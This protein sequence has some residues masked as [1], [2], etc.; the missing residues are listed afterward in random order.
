MPAAK[1]PK[2][3]AMRARLIEAASRELVDGDGSL[4]LSAVAARAGVSN[5]LPYR[6]F[7]SK[8]QLMAAVVDDFFDR[9]D[10]EIFEPTLEEV[11]SW[12]ER[13]QARMART[14]E[15]FYRDP[16]APVVVGLLS[17]DR[18]AVVALQARVERQV[19]AAARNIIRGQK[20]GSIGANLDPRLRAAMV[21]GGIHRT[22]LTA[23][24]SSPKPAP[25]HVTRELSH[26]VDV[27]LGLGEAGISRL[28]EHPGSEV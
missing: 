19:S 15:F 26:F 22:L 4:E 28:R 23:L 2:G 27:V 11:G 3:A 5:G 14:V 10:R 1:T 16:L 6:Y 17:G 8:A 13:E 20:E 7:A 9:F 18:D 12:R 25:E 24:A 21:M